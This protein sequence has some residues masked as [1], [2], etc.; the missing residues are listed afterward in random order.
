MAWLPQA[1]SVVGTSS[2]PS[3]TASNTVAIVAIAVTGLIGVVGPIVTG[4]F[5]WRNT[6]RTIAAEEERQSKA[7]AEERGRLRDTLATEERRM[8][9]EAIRGVLDHGAVLINRIQEMLGG[10]KAQGDMVEVPLGF[11]EMLSAATAFQGR[12]RLWFDDRS[13]IVRAFDDL[14]TTSIFKS[15]LGEALKSAQPVSR[16]S[17][18]IRKSPSAV[19]RAHR[20]RAGTSQALP[21]RSTRTP[22]AVPRST[23]A[24]TG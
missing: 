1:F 20:R 19:R 5:L 21:R 10:L 2:S 22:G 11:D 23:T 6:G 12:L 14:L 4:I 9:T 15:E 13:D 8:R 18:N 7:L 3:A 17:R 24:H 16:Q